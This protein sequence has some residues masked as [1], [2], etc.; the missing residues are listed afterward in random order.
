MN[1]LILTP[2]RVGSTMLQR[3]VTIYMQFHKYDRPVI[4]L[5]ELTNGLMKYYSPVFNQEVLGKPN[6]GTKWGYYQ[7]LPEIREMLQSVDHFK[8]SRLAQYHIENRKDSIADQLDLYHYLNENFYVICCQRENL[9]DHVLS[10]G[11]VDH[12]KR[13]NVYTIEEKYSTFKDIYKNKISIPPEN[14]IKRLN[15]YKRYLE[16]VDTHFSVNSYFV[17]DKHLN[18][19]EDYILNLDIFDNQEQKKTWKDTFNI[20][21]S[22]WN[23]VHYHL[24]DLSGINNQITY[25]QVESDVP[26]LSVDPNFKVDISKLEIQSV[27]NREKRLAGLSPQLRKFMQNNVQP[28][29]ESVKNLHELVENKVLVS[30]VPYK[31]QTMLEKK[32]LITNFKEC[33][34]V[35]NNWVATNN[36]GKMYQEDELNEL[37]TNEVQNWHVKPL[38]N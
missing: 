11:I 6:D 17:Y 23:A 7:T 12:S 15:H 4:N 16:W 2:D 37:I 29:M 25:N 1:V 35:Y 27:D 34:D 19:V 33:V 10:W 26:L 36:L 8:T 38:L 22:D 14:I 31:L 24:S 5:H 28:Y 21:F 3:L 18:N 9:L 13:L 30:G 20:E 32:L